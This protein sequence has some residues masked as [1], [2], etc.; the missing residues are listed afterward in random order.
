M[1]FRVARM[2]RVKSGA[3]KA[4]KS[5]PKDVRDEYQALYGVRWEELFHAPAGCSSQQAKVLRSEWEGRIDSRIKALRAK[6]RG[7]GHDL[8]QRDARA[9]AGEWYRWFISQ[10]EE[11]PGRPRDWEGLCWDFEDD[12]QEAARDPETGEIG[13]LDMEAPEVREYV[14]KNVHSWFADTA[15][16]FLASR[17]EAPTPAAMTMFLDELI[18]EFH[19]AITLLRRRAIGDYSPDQHLQTLPEYRRKAAPQS[20]VP[21]S[22]KTAMQL[23]EA[24]FQALTLLLGLWSAGVSCSLRWTSTSPGVISK[25]CPMKKPND[26]WRRS[27]RR[28]AVPAR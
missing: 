6:Q 20:A 21:R 3:F 2:A 27:L 22:G 26:G 15:A 18:R 19:T 16:Q 9:L 5:I 12:V 10:Y 7:E 23:F 1:A 8:T 14:R 24:I 11:S 28:S 13:E 25:L 4:R 17:G